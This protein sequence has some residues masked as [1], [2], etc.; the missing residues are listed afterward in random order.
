MLICRHG[1]RG[2]C[3]DN[4]CC[5]YGS[6][7]LTDVSSLHDLED[8]DNVDDDTISCSTQVVTDNDRRIS[9]DAADNLSDLTIPDFAV[10]CRVKSFLF[11]SVLCFKESKKDRRKNEPN[12]EGKMM[13]YLLYFITH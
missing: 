1:I 11:L 4:G 9:D 12:E 8:D 2:C 10:S 6:D 5:V 3:H 7:T 13:Y